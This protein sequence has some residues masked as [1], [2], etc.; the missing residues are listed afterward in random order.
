VTKT[1]TIEIASHQRSCCA[2]RAPRSNLPQ[3]GTGM[4][5]L[6]RENCAF[7]TFQATRGPPPGAKQGRSDSF[8]GVGPA[9][10][11]P[12]AGTLHR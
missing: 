4:I 9:T 5:A 12:A 10:P 7:S 8:S 2:M 11:E 1:H 3:L 6:S